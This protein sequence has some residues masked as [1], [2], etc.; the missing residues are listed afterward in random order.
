MNDPAILKDLA[1]VRNVSARY[2]DVENALAD[3]FEADPVCVA[4]PGLGGMGVHYIN[5]ERVQDPEINL[6]EP[7]IPLYASS[8]NGMKLVGVENMFAI[9]EPGSDVPDSPP[10]SPNLFGREFDGPMLGYGPGQPP[11]YDLH[12]WV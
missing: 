1:A 5:M 10:P 4:A 8:G 12:V 2:H 9:G 6:L 11:H 7:E 3:G